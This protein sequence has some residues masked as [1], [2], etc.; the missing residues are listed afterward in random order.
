MHRLCRILAIAFAVMWLPVTA[1]C[2]LEAIGAFDFEQVADEGCCNPQDGCTD[3]ACEMIEGANLVP[4]SL[5]VK[6]PIEVAI[7]NDILTDTLVRL[8]AET[9]LTASTFP[10]HAVRT[11]AWE[12]TWHIARRAAGLARSPS[13]RV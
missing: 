6:A 10:N 2:E 13:A 1:H 9:S 4:S 5:S 12:P 8:L 11:T 7:T 3:D